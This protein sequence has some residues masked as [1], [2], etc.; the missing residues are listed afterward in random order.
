MGNYRDDYENGKIYFD[1]SV[2]VGSVKK[3][4]EDEGEEKGDFQSLH[5]PALGV[6]EDNNIRS[7]PTN[8]KG[9]F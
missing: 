3:T 1:V 9:G 8:Q 2:E 4:N 6:D 5:F 7:N